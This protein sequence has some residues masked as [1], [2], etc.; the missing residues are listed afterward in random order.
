M[1]DYQRPSS[2]KSQF[3]QGGGTPTYGLTGPPMPHLLPEYGD[4]PEEVRDKKRR[5]DRVNSDIERNRFNRPYRGPTV[6]RQNGVIMK[7]LPANPVTG[8]EMTNIGEPGR[9]FPFDDAGISI[10]DEQKKGRKGIEDGIRREEAGRNVRTGRKSMTTIEQGMQEAIKPFTRPARRPVSGGR[11]DPFEPEDDLIIN[12][13]GGVLYMA[14]IA[15]M[16][17]RGMPDESPLSYR[18][19]MYR[20]EKRSKRR[21]KWVRSIDVN[22][23]ERDRNEAKLYISSIPIDD[24]IIARQSGP[25]IRYREGNRVG[26]LVGPPVLY[27]YSSESGSDGRLETWNQRT[28]QWDFLRYYKK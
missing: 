14:G 11:A 8:G 15:A 3:Y 19:K 4:T 25:R 27:R 23:N 13:D 12:E 22:M 2:E 20:Q 26:R 9:P 1:A 18:D 7:S 10:L 24:E 16:S 21:R 28:K 6:Y 17:F 5:R